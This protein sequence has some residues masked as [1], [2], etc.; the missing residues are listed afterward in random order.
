MNI[1]A[2]QLASADYP[3]SLEHDSGAGLVDGILLLNQRDAV[4][5]FFD[6][7]NIR[8]MR[9]QTWLL[10]AVMAVYAI[11]YI[12]VFMAYFAKGLLG[13]GLLAVGALVVDGLLALRA[14]QAGAIQR[15]IRQASAALLVGHMVVLTIFHHSNPIAT[16]LWLL[17]LG[18]LATRYLLA[19]GE[20][21]ALFGALYAVMAGGVTAGG[22]WSESGMPGTELV[23]FGAMMIVIFAID[24]GLTRNRERRF[25]ARWR[26]EAGRH[27]ERLRMKQ[28]LEYAREIQ[29]SMLPRGAPDVPW[30]GIAALSLPATEVGGDY[31]DYFPLD[32][33]CLAVVVGDVTGHG[34][35]SGLV[36]SGVRSSLNLLQDE[37]GSPRRILT[38]VNRMLKKTSTPRM[39]MTLAVAVLDRAKG[40]LTVGLAGHP[41][42]LLVRGETGELIE[43]GH[44]ALPLG[45]LANAE[46]R[47]HSVP[48]EAGDVIFAFSDGLVETANQR[49]E[50]YGWDRLGRALLKYCSQEA[51]SNEIRDA[52]LRDVWGFKSDAEQADDV[53]MVVIRVDSVATVA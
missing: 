8:R 18:L 14:G 19:A 31:Y 23:V 33:N 12:V 20:E 37:M 47:E 24:W 36:L 34:V 26:G 17:V 25:V 43:V 41:P 21:S 44:T 51:T 30:L 39:L 50:P 9:R 6:Q 46:F 3:P 49:E 15:N 38:R 42:L 1:A 10:G 52:I 48:I 45:A 7:I 32:D 13:F 35:A 5:R 16:G 53:T 29:L 4:R 28:E 11:I 40:N 2:S 27:R 22:L